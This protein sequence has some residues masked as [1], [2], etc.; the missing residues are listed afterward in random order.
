MSLS[1]SKSWNSF[2]S[3]FTQ[4]AQFSARVARKLVVKRA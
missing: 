4:F 3:Q 2:V 1:H